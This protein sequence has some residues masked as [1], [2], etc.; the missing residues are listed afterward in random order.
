MTQRL[1][2]RKEATIRAPGQ[3]VVAAPPVDA[4]GAAAAA[5]AAGVPGAQNPGGLAPVHPDNTALP[6][7]EKPAAVADQTNDVPGGNAAQVA[8]GTDRRSYQQEEAQSTIRVTSPPASTRKRRGSTSSI[9]SKVLAVQADAGFAIQADALR[10]H[11]W[12]LGASASV[13]LNGKQDGEGRSA[14]ALAAKGARAC[15][16]ARALQSLETG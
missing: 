5:A 9:L 4:A 10:G 8:T 7:V 6:A 3:T 12:L 11:S 14:T 1:P 15:A 2:H 16:A 13:V